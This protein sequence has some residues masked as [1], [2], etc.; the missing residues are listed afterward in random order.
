MKKIAVVILGVV[1]AASACHKKNT[2]SSEG[3]VLFTRL[4]VDLSSMGNDFLLDLN[5]KIFND[6]CNGKLKVYK[7]D[8]L[9]PNSL[10]KEE[11]VPKIGGYSEALEIPVDPADPD[12]TID[13]VIFTAFNIKDVKGY[14]FSQSW[15][16]EKN[17]DNYVSRLNA[18]ALRYVPYIAGIYLNEQALFWISFEDFKQYLSKPQL[19]QI[20]NLVLEKNVTTLTEY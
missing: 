8:S 11:D 18:V 10:Y 4:K 19:E 15:I 17:S 14:E 1:M 2:A 16:H 20:M 6:A 5:E 13:T 7:F 12:Y 3:D 9:S